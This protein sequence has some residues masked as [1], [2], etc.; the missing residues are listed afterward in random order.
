MKDHFSFRGSF[1]FLCFIRVADSYVVARVV[2]KVEMAHNVWKHLFVL[3]PPKST[4]EK[5][6][7]TCGPLFALT[8]GQG[9]RRRLR[10]L[11]KR[12]QMYRKIRVL[13]QAANTLNIQKLQVLYL[14]RRNTRSEELQML[15]KKQI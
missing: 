2:Q 12:R 11:R 15:Q 7:E 9:S 14:Q 13:S 10:Y 4:W 8:K 1:S 3:V 5:H 6:K